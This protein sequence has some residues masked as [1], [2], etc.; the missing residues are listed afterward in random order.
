MNQWLFLY[1][2]LAPVLFAW[3]LQ[4]VLK[5]LLYELQQ[6]QKVIEGQISMLRRDLSVRAEEAS[7]AA[8]FDKYGTYPDHWKN[9]AVPDSRDVPNT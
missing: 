6:T 7:R 4:L 5:P 3:I 2:C 1:V 8:Y 9:S